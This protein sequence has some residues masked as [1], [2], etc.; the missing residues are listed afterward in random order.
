MLL[1]VCIALAEHAGDEPFFLSARVAGDAIGVAPKDANELLKRLVK[2]GL[3][4]DDYSSRPT[5][6]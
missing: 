2:Q 6:T 5:T 4:D 3:M 1:R